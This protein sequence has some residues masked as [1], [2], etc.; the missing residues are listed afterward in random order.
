MRCLVT[1]TT[2]G[3]SVVVHERDAAFEEVA[4]GLGLD[5]LFTTTQSPPPPRPTG[6]GDCVDLAV[7]PGLCRWSLWRF[8]PGAEVR[9]HHTDTVDF[10]VV[11]EGRMDLVLD[12]G[13]HALDAGDCVVVTGV[14]H[15]WRAGPEGC[16]V[17]A[18]AVG[19]SRAQ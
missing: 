2:D 1:G 14:D 5:T 16:T 19:S 3:R 12:D 7:D 9:K 18:L 4:A 15:A 11:V 6:R 17:A 10:D 13:A 8:A